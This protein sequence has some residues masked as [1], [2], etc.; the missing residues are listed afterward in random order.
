MTG[1][2]E[3]GDRRLIGRYYALSKIK[4]PN[5]IIALKIRLF[6]S[7]ILREVPFE[8]RENLFFNVIVADRLQAE[9]DGRY[10]TAGLFRMIENDYRE[11]FLSMPR[12][13]G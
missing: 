2:R 3:W 11:R 13:T 1:V 9:S 10:E 6:E 12:R 4:G 7:Y 5:R 8:R